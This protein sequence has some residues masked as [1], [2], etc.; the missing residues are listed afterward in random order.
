MKLLDAIAMADK[1]RP[2][3]L[4][5]DIK[6]RWLYELEG[7]IAEL[8][9]VEI[10]PNPY[11]KDSEEELL[12]PYPKDNIYSLYLCAMI[13][14]ALEDTQLYMNDMIVANNAIAEAKAWWRRHHRKKSGSIRCFPWQSPIKEEVEEDVTED[15]VSDAAETDTSIPTE[16]D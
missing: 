7:E 15:S 16:G 1:L 14:N 6:A 5:N 10:S 12:M 4:E 9:D 2:N 13:D 8:M 11:P 3:A